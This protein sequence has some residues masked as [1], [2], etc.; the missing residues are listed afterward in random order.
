MN[1]LIRPLFIASLVLAGCS[2]PVERYLLPEITGVETY[3]TGVRTVEVS[4]L[5]LPAY[6][7]DTEIS[8]QGEDGVLRPTQSGFWA[9][10]PDRALTELLAA[11]LDQSLSS[12]V[13][14]EPWPFETPADVRV[15]V[16]VGK[17]SGVPGQ[18]LRFTGQYFLTSPAHGNLE[19]AY[20][21]A[22]SVPMAD[23]TVTS[24][25]AAQSNAMKRLVNDIAKRIATGR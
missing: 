3:R 12:S 9:D 10:E 18:S 21:F 7:G 8:L 17:L 1:R 6:A 16:K 19:R 2:G 5:D 20:R 23:D 15:T 25:A 24:V 13:A 22:Y 14:T 4:T 11:G